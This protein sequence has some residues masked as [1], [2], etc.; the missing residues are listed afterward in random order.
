MKGLLVSLGTV[1]WMTSAT[2]AGDW[3]FTGHADSEAAPACDVEVQ[4]DVLEASGADVQ[5]T[6]NTA[7]TYIGNLQLMLPARTLHQ[8]RVMLVAELKSDDTLLASMSLKAL[9]DHQT[10]MFEDDTEQAMLGNDVADGWQLRQLSLPIDV[11]TSQV[12]LGVLLQGNG[13]LAL[14][15]VHLVVS[16]PGVISEAA[17]TY[18]DHVLA[19]L[20]QQTVERHDLHWYALEPQMRVLAS[21]A[22]TTAEVYPA[23]RYALAAIGDRR[24]ML[25]T[26]QVVQALHASANNEAGTTRRLALSDGAQ[27]VLAPMAPLRTAQN[28]F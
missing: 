17:V 4:G 21:G 25:L 12:R 2:A 27:L 8:R 28:V 20:K 24:N 15:N 5:L 18:L 6:C 19:L 1:V 10:L 22:Q 9:H 7:N 26:P 11:T 23:I 3:Q 13:K 14:R 16:E